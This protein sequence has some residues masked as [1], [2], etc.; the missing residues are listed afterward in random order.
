MN[1]DAPIT[2]TVRN[3]RDNVERLVLFDRFIPMDLAAVT[4]VTLQLGATLVDSA[5]ASAGAITWTE[6]QAYRGDIVDVLSLKL[7][8]EGLVPGVYS[9]V[10]LV[11]YDAVNVNGV[12]VENAAKVTVI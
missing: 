5:T 6:Q 12:E 3:G 9:D 4:R 11:V 8:G 10:R 2:L 7:G 1:L